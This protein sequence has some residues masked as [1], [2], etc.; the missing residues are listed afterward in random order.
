MAVRE[1]LVTFTRDALVAGKSREDISGAMEQAGWSGPEVAEA[2]AAF[3]DTDFTPPVPR[4][5]AV[6]S[7]RDFF[8]YVLIFGMMLT[9]A[10]ALVVLCFNLIELTIGDT[11]YPR[12]LL[13]SI[14]DGIAVLIVSVPL[15]VWL[16][17]REN[18]RLAASPGRRRSAIRKWV[19]SISL[20]IAAG[21]FLGDVIYALQQLLRGDLTLEFLLRVIVVAVVSGGVFQFYRHDLSDE[22]GAA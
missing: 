4:P 2:L 18:K 20:L 7:A 19:A 13:N 22:E 8:I 10:I 5:R 6:V 14:R 17:L 1:E 9:S 16:H 15:L 12:Y 3:A 21:V 11:S